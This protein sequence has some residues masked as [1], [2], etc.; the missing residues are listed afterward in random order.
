M[1]KAGWRFASR[2]LFAAL[3]VPAL[4]LLVYWG[5]SNAAALGEFPVGQ[6]ALLGV[7]LVGT[8][9]GR[10]FARSASEW[11]W[12]LVLFVGFLI[13]GELANTA[14]IQAAKGGTP[15]LTSKYVLRSVEFIAFV[16][17]WL[18]VSPTGRSAISLEP[19]FPSLTGRRVSFPW[20]LIL[21][22]IGAVPIVI[23]ALLAHKDLSDASITALEQFHRVQSLLIMAGC[24]LAVLVLVRELLLG[25]AGTGAQPKPDICEPG[26]VRPPTVQE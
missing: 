4:V 20:R 11:A 23:G 21:L 26:T 18:V 8:A 5:C 16:L 13:L 7:L 3:A 2:F 15:A 19:E 1:S 22:I 9:G 10:L 25:C 12:T 14:A 24:F 17:A 6:S